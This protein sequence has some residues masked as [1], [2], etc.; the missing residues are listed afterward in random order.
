MEKEHIAIV[1]AGLVGSMQA[2]YMAQRGYRVSVFERRGDIREAEI[3]AGKSI[4]LALSDR[5]FR[6]LAGIGMEEAIRQISIP[7]KGRMIH[8]VEGNLNFQPYSK[9][10]KCIYS[11]SRGGLN[12]LLLERADEYEDVS[13]HFNEKCKD[14]DLRNNSITF[15][16]TET[17]AIT[18]HHFDRIFGTDGAF[19]AVRGRLQKTDRF[20]YSQEYL[21][22]GYKELEIPPLPGGKHR[23]EV[24]ALHIWPRGEYMLIALPNLDGSYT[25]TLFFPFEGKVSFDTLNSDAAVMEF[26]ST[27]FPDA[28]EHMPNLM[29]DFNTNPTSSLVMIKCFP[30]HYDDA[31]CL[32][33]DAAHAIVPF[34]GQGM[35]AGFEDCTYFNDLMDTH[36]SDWE[37]VL[38]EY[39]RIRKPAGD[40]ILELAVRNY[41][42]MRDLTA[43]P[44]FVLQKKIEKR[45]ALQHPHLWMPL[46]EQVTFSHIPYED[47]LER[48]DIQNGIMKRVMDRDDIE[49]VWDSAEIEEAIIAEVQR[50]QL[51][52][53]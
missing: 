49:D 9:D 35:N 45:F 8:D 30:W 18:T 11:V 31:V 1:G 12:Q 21:T 46:Y 38:K 37:V 34:Y 42:E 53:L 41:I 36:N 13:L 23:M 52:A 3:V 20:N 32:M 16:N 28:L 15:K 14:F 6:A 22:H 26:F 25:V 40:A 4:N 5:G 44:R 51:E 7:M 27:T 33:G 24:N 50:L 47:A 10:G 43:D 29:E 48:G 39:S 17:G 19:S 2:C